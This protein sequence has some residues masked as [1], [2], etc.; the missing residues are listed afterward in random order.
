MKLHSLVLAG[1]LL[2]A[3]VTLSGCAAYSWQSYGS[4]VRGHM[5]SEGATRADVLASMGEPNGVYR[6]SDTEVFVYRGI[7]GNNYFFGIY[8]RVK[9]DDTVVVMDQAGN[10]LTAV[11]VEVGRARA[12]F[13]MP[14]ELGGDT[15][16]IPLDV[17]T[18]GPDNYEYTF[19][20]SGN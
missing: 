13:A 1:G 11:P 5:I 19:E 16:P 18:R 7:K 9:R 12:F 17:L 3:A 6:A 8:Q 15:H 10:V 2:A 4:P 14:G 20:S